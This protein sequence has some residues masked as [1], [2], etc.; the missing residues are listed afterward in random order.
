MNHFAVVFSRPWWLLCFIPAIV[1]TL[2]P[3]FKLAKKYRRTRNRVISMILH[4]TVMSLSIFILSGITF[5][6]AVPNEKNEIILLVDVSDTEELSAEKRDGF[7][8]TVLRQGRYDDYRVGVVTFGFTQQ[9]AVPL[10]DDVD[11]VY[12]TYENAALP[13]V[14]ATNIADA[15][16]YTKTLF[17]NPES[18]KIVL[19]TDGK[20]TDKAAASVIRSVS[21]SGIK[22]DVANI[23]SAYEE[24]DVEISDVTVPDY[25]VGIGEEFMVGVTVR[26]NAAASATIELS[27]NGVTD[28][29]AT[30]SVEVTGG[31]QTF[32]LKHTCNE[33][34]LHKLGV[35]IVS[36]GSTLDKNDEYFT[37]FYLE[38]FDKVL[39]IGR[40]DTDSEALKELLAAE[41]FNVETKNILEDDDFL[42]VTVDYL[43]AYDQ[44]ILNNIANRDMPEGFS[45]TLYSYVNVYGGGL[46]TVGGQDEAGN[47]NAYDR[48]DM[49]GSVYQQ[50]LPVQAITYT[51]PVGVVVI[52][53][54]S[55]SMASTDSATGRSY[56]EWATEG[57]KSCLNALS[58]RDYVGVM[59]LDDA[60]KTVLPLTR[61]TQEAKIL[62][63]IDSIDEA[64]GGTVFP[65]AIEGA[66]E[67][68]R[69]EKNIDKRHIIIVTDGGVPEA[70]QEAY[71]TMIETFYQTD[72]ITLSV[73]LVG[74]GEGSDA[75]KL[76]KSAVEK[77]HGR[78]YAVTD[79]STLVRLMREDLNVPEIKD[80]NMEPFYPV[81]SNA[82][83]ALFNGVEYG[84]SEDGGL[85]MNVQLEG[86]FGVKVKTGADLILA[87]EYS[88]PIYAQWKFGKGTVGSFM[89]DLCGYWSS[90]FMS[91]SSGER[92]IL[93]VVNNLMPIEDIR[94]NSMTVVLNEQNYTNRLDVYTALDE[95]GY[96]SGKLINLADGSE[97]EISLNEVTAIKEGDGQPD[98][99]V[100]AAFGSENNY[101]RCYFVV[102]AGGVYKIVLEKYDGNGTLKESAE[103]YKSFAYSKEYDVFAEADEKVLSEQFALWAQRGKGSVIQDLEDPIEI[104]DGFVT[105]LTRTFDPR[106][107]FMITA[108]VLFLLDIA[109]RKFKFKWPHEL[110]REYKK[111]KNEK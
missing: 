104:F 48:A 69:A 84:V 86:F 107:A 80:V 29:S 4:L 17:Q 87:G 7:I 16:T 44:V 2:I 35:K 110:I 96:V 24:D 83:S 68:L 103:L 97:T 62:A 45:E 20:E 13:D 102:K 8:Q 72:K 88:V 22:V 40:N 12:E 82:T 99:F 111:K 71:E 75:A 52:I 19:I 50:I 11:S 9:Y 37:Y 33:Q 15:L 46:L 66:G 85:R 91:D 14:S 79:F 109:V 1:L 61:R 60:D 95:G 94:P 56:L 78:L 65:G 47:A 34:G 101:S 63:A 90:S 73:V 26:S 59:T 32:T 76:M 54:R 25:H 93:N 3:Y 92:F 106:T 51:P 43:R 53:D 89:C 58:E 27:D 5:R 81:V 70:Q 39:I 36:D 105:E 64:T 23:P 10:T 18:A 41:N 108:I 98:C 100:T 74:S 49:A 30:Q 57:A 31:T 55:G 28:G 42:D 21:A 6:Y 77:G 67:M 38:V